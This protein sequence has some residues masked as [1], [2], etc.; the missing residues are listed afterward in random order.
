MLS[1]LKT[2][3]C[4]F[5]LIHAVYATGYKTLVLL[6][7]ENTLYSKQF[8]YLRHTLPDYIKSQANDLD[9]E[10]AGSIEPY[11][12]MDNS[13]YDNAAILLGKYSVN[14][15]YIEVSY[16]IYNMMNWEKLVVDS[17]EC[18]F[19]DNE[20][21]KSNMMFSAQASL[22]IIS[23]GNIAAI[24]EELDKTDKKI[25]HS[26]SIFDN[27]YMSLGDF[28][29]E[30]D[31]HDTWSRMNDEGNQ[32]GNRYYKDISDSEHD[33]FLN[34]SREHNTERLFSYLDK[35][36]LNPY[37]VHIDDITMES[38]PNN[39]QYINI[40]F[41]VS[42]TIKKSMIEDILATLPHS[43]ISDK[44]GSVRLKFFNSDFIF[45][46]SILDQ[47][48]LMQHQIIPVIFLS[49][50]YGRV[51]SMY[52]DSWQGES[53]NIFNSELSVSTGNDFYPLI[54]IT[55][56]DNNLLINLDVSTIDI[57]YKFKVKRDESRD[58]SKIVVKFL[59]QKEVLSLLDEYY[60]IYNN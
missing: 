38:H 2:Y 43:N 28:A 5:I 20:C 6:E 42:Y 17:Y 45:E 32:Y 46:D 15:P 58:N 40:S 1:L 60:S 29:V 26:L 48:A 24:E 55:P 22:G 37:D 33:D 50:A 14:E 41:P 19:S 7:F 53:I 8:D 59:T 36:L 11:L 27:L 23:S 56:G 57:E 12:G 31:L 54:A 10:Y 16:T 3:L 35:I 47:Y 21:I 4:Y 44:R 30:V 9:I 13:K 52:I 34:N 39:S 51:T 18:H 49:D 25:N